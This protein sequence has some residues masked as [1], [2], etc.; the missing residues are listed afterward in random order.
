M[1]YDLFLKPRGGDFALADLESYFGEREHYSFEGT[2]AWYQ[3]EATGVYFVFEYREEEEDEGEYFPIAFNMNY[4]RPSFFIREAE[5]EVTAFIAEFDLTVDDPQV[6]GM[7]TGEYDPEKFNRGWL[8]GNEFGY[9]SILRDHPHTFSLPSA[10]LE[11]A[12]Q[13]NH[14]REKLQFEAT[15][16]VFVP[17]IMLLNYRQQTVT[18]CVWPDAIPSILPPVDIL[19]IGRKELAPRR[20]FKRTEDMVIGNWDEMRPLLDSHKTRMQGDAFYLR[21]EKVPAQLKRH[22]QQMKPIDLDSLERLPF[23]QVL[24]RELVEKYRT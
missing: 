5:P 11:Q 1:S 13:W 10:R 17:G 15:E 2:Q 3:N 16:D 19:L 7:G 20:F 4:F 6:N 21:Y 12:W 14:G 24:D 23:D 9:Q 22:I 8:N 18:A